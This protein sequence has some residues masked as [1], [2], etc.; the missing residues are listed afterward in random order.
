MGINLYRSPILDHFDKTRSDFP[1]R[2][3]LARYSSLLRQQRTYPLL[4]YSSKAVRPG[5]TV[6]GRL[7][8]KEPI[9]I[10]NVVKN[11]Q[12]PSLRRPE[13]SLR[14]SA[15]AANTAAD[16]QG[17]PSGPQGEVRLVCCLGSDLHLHTPCTYKEEKLLLSP[18]MGPCSSLQPFLLLIHSV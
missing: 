9:P 4:S 3:R 13:G 8:R 1:S 12:Q 16:L 5:L 18:F 14:C 15:S 17:A 10:S 2:T 6:C 7:S 11:A